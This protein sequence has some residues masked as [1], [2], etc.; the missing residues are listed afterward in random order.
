MKRKP[1]TLYMPSNGTEG[2]AFHVQYCD[3]CMYQHPD[4]E[5][6]PQCTE[7]QLIGLNG[8]QPPEWIYNKEGY[9]TCTRFKFWDWLNKP[10]GPP[11]P[12]AI[13]PAQ[14]LIP[15]ELSDIIG[16]CDDLHITHFGII[17]IQT[18]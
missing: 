1:G 15:F 14:L 3:R 17:E 12:I 6:A 9:P 10:D 18:P 16:N 5:K 13:D 11:P 7:V 8:D 2:I 4:P